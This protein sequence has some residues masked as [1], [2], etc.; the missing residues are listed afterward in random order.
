MASP[1]EKHL[2]RAEKAL[3]KNKTEQAIEEFEAA[4]KLAP[5]HVD[6]IRNLAD[7][8]ARLNQTDSANRYN[9]LLFDRY[10]EQN[11]AAKAIALYHKNLEG[12]TQPPERLFRFAALLHRQS[13]T[14]EAVAAYKQ[15]ADLFEKARQDAAALQC[16]EK[17]A[18]L[19]PES[20]EFQVRLAQ[21]AQRL[22]KAEAAAKAYLRAGQ[23]V[24]ADKVEQALE[25]YE[26][27]QKLCPGER[28]I[29]LSYAQAQI[30]AGKPER[31]V[32]LLLP[33][34]AES[35]QDPAILSTLGEALLVV[36]RFREAEEVL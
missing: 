1:L 27:A 12:T 20:A 22:G 19:D 30:A 34:Y 8:Y 11:D 13:K 29:L 15:A 6:V 17:M 18:A 7:L 33:L 16:L 4:H 9:G 14:A 2:E 3:S 10:F 25:F 24:R 31:A 23:L 36:K 5:S 28:S 35:E 26:E 21:V 32:D